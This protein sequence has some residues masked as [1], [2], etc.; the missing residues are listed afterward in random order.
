LKKEVAMRTPKETRQG[1]PV[2]R[3]LIFLAV[4]GVAGLIFLGGRTLLGRINLD[5]IPVAGEWQ[6]T[7]KPWRLM[8]HPDKTLVS[9]TA[10]SQRAALQEWT[11]GPGTYSVDYFG[12]LWVKLNNGKV[13]RASLSPAS[14]R[15]FDLIDADTEV[16]TVFERAMQPKP[17][18]PEKASPDR[19]GS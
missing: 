3:I 13:Y 11:S 4:V 15:R 12:T 10:P 17:P 1:V 19:S 2:E 8:L 7:T 18:E 6:S 9:S 5:T 16:V 14:P